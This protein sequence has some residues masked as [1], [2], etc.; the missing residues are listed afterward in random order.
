MR[1]IA[2]MIRRKFKIILILILSGF[3]ESIV[4]KKGAGCMYLNH[5]NDIIDR[6]LLTVV[7][8]STF[9]TL[10]IIGNLKFI[11]RCLRVRHLF[12][13]DIRSQVTLLWFRRRRPKPT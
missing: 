10:G 2:S 9:D 11:S 7:C 1:E 12:L 4:L 3:F 13:M 6:K 8:L 5:D